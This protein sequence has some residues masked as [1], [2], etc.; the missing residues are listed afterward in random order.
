MGKSIWQQ[1]AEMGI[2]P[3]KADGT[4]RGVNLLRNLILKKQKERFYRHDIKI[5]RE[6][7]ALGTIYL[8]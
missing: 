3:F 5:S 2:E 4:P 8:D 1:A 6:R 7:R